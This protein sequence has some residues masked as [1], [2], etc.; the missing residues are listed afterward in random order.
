[1]SVAAVGVDMAL[2]AFDFDGT[3]T[4]S[5]LTVLLG[6]EYDVAGE[7]RGLVEQGLRGEVDFADT[8]RQRVALLEGMPEARVDAAF[9]RCK[10]RDG[11]SDLISDLRRSGV[12]VA[13][14]TGTFERGVEAALDRAGVTVDHLVA[15]RLVIANGA[16]TGDVDGPLLDA[17]KDRA[18]EN[19]AL[20]E[21]LDLGR[22][23]AVGNGMTDV[24]MLQVAGSAIGFSPEPVVEDYCDVV[25]TSIQ[26]LRLH[27]EQHHV[28]DVAE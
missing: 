23:V 4:K 3:L 25:V 20:T 27:F 9:D 7:I 13:I 28:V 12:T 24:P 14:I 22:T 2:V 16:V 19:L 17:G 1:M 11:V 26:K 18:L 21:G 8:L 10:L 5:D 15:N 6:R